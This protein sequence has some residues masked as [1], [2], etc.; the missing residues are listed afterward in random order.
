M[1]ASP[2]QSPGGGARLRI[3][4]GSPA[5][6]LLVG[7]SIAAA[8][9]GVAVLGLVLPVIEARLVSRFV[10]LGVSLLGLQFVVGRA[11]QLS[12]CHGVFI[13]VGSY[14]ATI[15]IS[16]YGLPHLVGVGLAPVLGFAVGCLVGLLAL[17]IRANYL[18]PVTLSVAVVFPMI[19][20]RFGWFTGGASG[21]PKVR[22]L[23]PPSFLGLESTQ[24][25]LWTHLVIVA[26]AALAV[27][28]MRNVV[29]SPKGMSVRAIADNPLSA[30][31]SGINVRRT[32]VAAYGFGS[33]FGA[34]GGA[35][36][37][38]D[39]PVVGADSY[40]LFQSLGAYA[41]VMVGGAASMIG[42]VLGAA[43]LVG[44]PWAMES[45]ELRAG[46]GLVLGGL[47]VL[48]TLVAP[49]GVAV[50]VRA[51]VVRRFDVR[52]PVAERAGTATASEP[53][54]HYRAPDEHSR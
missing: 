10:A 8:F 15:S 35:L 46:P 17:R 54:A 11:G 48:S 47:L 23:K 3:R 26:I 45:I 19:L 30:S 27:V 34:L 2:S 52:H 31:T 43:L 49:G 39:T 9:V 14:T 51:L 6:K 28:V 44:V 38:L 7:G 32:R 36:L 1:A 12:L 40:N 41:A 29:L 16:R 53:V 5:W 22:E 42:A 21:L 18:G 20:K 50:A 33:A 13:G 25:Y 4:H 24:Y 37:V